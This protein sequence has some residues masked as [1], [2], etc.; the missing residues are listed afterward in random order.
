MLITLSTLFP[1]MQS[2]Q[3]HSLVY[4]GQFSL[5]R[6][7]WRSKKTLSLAKARK[8][9]IQKFTHLASPTKSPPPS[10]PQTRK[11]KKRD[12]LLFD[13]PFIYLRQFPFQQMDTQSS[14]LVCLFFPRKSPSLFT[15][16]PVLPH[17]TPTN[18]NPA[19][20]SF[21]FFFF[22]LLFFVFFFFPRLLC[23]YK[24]T[25]IVA[26]FTPFKARRSSIKIK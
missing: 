14:S 26:F 22:L 7:T 1:G 19:S 18:E 8:E 10:L 23:L 15:D 21:P 16:L 5:P 3:I 20:S 2:I 12:S 6:G 9:N 13:R 11:G 4:L 24:N 17:L 25:N